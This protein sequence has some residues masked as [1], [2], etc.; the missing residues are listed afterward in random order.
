MR[1]SLDMESSGGAQIDVVYGYPVR[2]AASFTDYLLWT[3][4]SS[5]SSSISSSDVAAGASS[6]V[7]HGAKSFRHYNTA[8]F[9]IIVIGF[10]L[11]AIVWCAI[12]EAV[13]THNYPKFEINSISYSPLRINETWS[14][15]WTVGVLVRNTNRYT[16]MEYDDFQVSVYYKEEQLS[17]ATVSPLFL[18]PKRQTSVVASLQDHSLQKKKN[19]AATEIEKDRLTDGVVNFDVV[20]QVKMTY[21]FRFPAIRGTAKVL[22]MELICLDVQVGFPSQN[23]TVNASMMIGGPFP[24]YYP[25]DDILVSLL[26]SK[27]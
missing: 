24:C 19:S 9:S 16:R 26:R 21:L 3:R 25:L 14:G 22:R 6:P 11:A 27:S 23:A 1:N 5:S 17:T 20:L 18:G 15:N 12:G 2:P 4:T 7:N 13:N 8:L 10:L